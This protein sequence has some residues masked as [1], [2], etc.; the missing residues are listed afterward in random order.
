MIDWLIFYLITKLFRTI[1]SQSEWKGFL[2]NQLLSEFF[3]VL[4]S[5][6]ADVYSNL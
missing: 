5:K 6:F 1:V 2:N 4:K 3:K